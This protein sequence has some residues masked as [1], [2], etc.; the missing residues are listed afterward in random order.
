M[1]NP[2]FFKKSV[3]IIEPKIVKVEPMQNK[4]KNEV[5][6][7]IEHKKLIKKKEFISEKML[8]NRI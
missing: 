2:K 8:E 1:T 3:S 4:S 6:N 7:K 5:Q